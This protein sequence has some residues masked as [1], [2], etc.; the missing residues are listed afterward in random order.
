MNRGRNRR[1]FE[2]IGRNYDQPNRGRFSA[3]GLT[4]EDCDA[5]RFRRRVYTQRGTSAYVDPENVPDYNLGPEAVL[6]R[7]YVF[8]E[9]LEELAQEATSAEFFLEAFRANDGGDILAEDVS[10]LPKSDDVIFEDGPVADDEM[11]IDP[12]LLELIDPAQL[13]LPRSHTGVA[14]ID[15]GAHP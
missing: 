11:W 1:S 10:T 3:S 5:R 8:A 12:E 6:A 2:R 13:G 9:E 4:P 14:S 7:E 15:R